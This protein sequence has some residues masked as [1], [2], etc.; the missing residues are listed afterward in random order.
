MFADMTGVISQLSKFAYCALFRKINIKFLYEGIP[1]IKVY[2]TLNFLNYL[3]T[4]NKQK[5]K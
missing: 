2:T 3:Q 4:Q 1:I 5:V